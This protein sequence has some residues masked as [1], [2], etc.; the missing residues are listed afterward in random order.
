MGDF[1]LKIWVE[2][3]LIKEC[4]QDGYKLGDL[5]CLYIIRDLNFQSDG[6]TDQGLDKDLQVIMLL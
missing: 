1:H 2:N 3:E 6:F 5:F 4:E